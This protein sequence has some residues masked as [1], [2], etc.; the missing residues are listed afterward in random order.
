MFSSPTSVLV[1]DF[2]CKPVL[3]MEAQKQTQHALTRLSF[4]F[5]ELIDFIRRFVVRI[6][7]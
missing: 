4:R 1:T 7:S 3:L 6:V 5:K 2:F